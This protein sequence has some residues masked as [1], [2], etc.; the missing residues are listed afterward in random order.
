MIGMVEKVLE[1]TGTEIINV[2]ATCDSTESYEQ[3]MP[4]IALGAVL[5]NKFVFSCFSIPYNVKGDDKGAWE[6][7]MDFIA[8]S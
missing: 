8:A 1:R 5:R 2:C 3:C 4:L 6:E 7:R